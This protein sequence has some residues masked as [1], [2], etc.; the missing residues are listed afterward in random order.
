M[1]TKLRAL[2]LGERTY[3]W[4]ATIGHVAGHGVDIHRCVRVRVWGTGK[5]GRALEADLLAK[6]TSVGWMPAATDG[7]YPAP[8][9]VRCLVEHALALGW[10]PG[11]VGGTFRL[12]EEHEVELPGFLLTDRVRDPGA[13][14]PTA[15]VIRA[16]EAWERRV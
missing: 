16:A 3:T 14:D 6:A 5:T 10:D 13:P 2:R 9:D 15:R 4:R 7:S 1:R 11:A 12:V 8:A